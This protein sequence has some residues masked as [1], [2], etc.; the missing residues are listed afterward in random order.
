VSIQIKSP[1]DFWAGVLYLVF[2]GVAL[3]IG[4][5]Y[6]LGTALR[7][8]PGYFSIVL[9]IML[10]AIGSV[11]FIRSFLVRDDALPPLALKATILVI[12]SVLLCSYLLPRAGLIVALTVLMLGAAA[13]SRK[14]RSE[15]KRMLLLT[16]GTIIFCILVFVYLL[17][18]P[19]PLLG[20]WFF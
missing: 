1:K 2:G 16:I 14:F 7:M 13:A 19:L 4:R 12:G 9:S 17:G 6:S 18:V 5:D 11:V 15:W 10:M 8:G 3:I 20:V